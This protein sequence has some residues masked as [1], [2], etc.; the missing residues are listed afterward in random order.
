[1]VSDMPDECC[2]D[3]GECEAH[4]ICYCQR[5]EKDDRYTTG[6]YK[7][8]SNLERKILGYAEPYDCED[9]GDN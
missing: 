9:S 6:L 7:Y 3:R 5:D 4:P 2:E 1:M 8:A